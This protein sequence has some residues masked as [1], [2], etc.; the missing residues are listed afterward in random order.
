[1]TR[2]RPKHDRRLPLR[3]SAAL[4]G[5]AGLAAFLVPAVTVAPV[6]AA[7]VLAAAVPAARTA[8]LSGTNCTAQVVGDALARTGWQA[9][10]NTSSSSADAPWHALDGSLSTRFS[11]DHTQAAGMFLQLDLG[12]AQTFDELSLA[13]PGSPTD[14]ARGFEVQVSNNASSWATVASCTGVGVQQVVSFPA[15]TDRYVRVVVTAADAS[16]WW[17]VDE[18]NLYGPV[19]CGASAS[20]SALDRSHWAATANVPYNSSYAPALALDG[21][22]ATRFSTGAVQ[23]AGQYLQVD[24][25]SAHIFDE[26]ALLAPGSPTDYAPGYSVQISNDARSWTTVAS[27]TGTSAVEVT[28]FPP[29][30][31]RY[32]RVMVTQPDAKYWW[33]V[34]ELYLYS[35]VAQPTS[36]TTTSTSTT[37]TTTV[38]SS[39]TQLYSSADPVAA[40]AQVTYTARVTPNPGGGYVNFL[41]GGNSLPGCAQVALNTSNGLATCTTSYDAAGRYSVQAVYSGR[42]SVAGSPAY[43]PSASGVYAEVVNLPPPG[44]LLLSRDGQVFASG[45]AQALGGMT[46]NQSSGPA[47]SIA[48]TPSGRGY[49]LVSANGTVA[50]FGDARFYG[51]LPAL[52]KHVHDIVAIAATSDGKGYYLVGADGGFFTF[53]DATFHGSLPGIHVHVHDVVGMVASPG[54]AGYLLVGADGGVFNFGRARF[55][56]SLPGIHRHV[57]DVRAILPS[58]TGTGYVLVGADGGAFVF[59]TGVRFLGSLPGEGVRVDNVVGIALTPD[60]GGYWMAGADGRVYGFGDAQ[61]GAVPNGVTSNLPVAAIAGT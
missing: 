25:G 48:A 18:L 61:A 9:S 51:D 28:S 39:T 58:S 4:C 41:S 17:S 44:Y 26:V 45:A 37:T 16:Y 31:A 43:R 30:Y 24:T 32:V 54:G 47:V 59:G 3:L 53:G 52:G 23:Q 38:P 49:W 15:Q 10:S 14:Y 34:D 50:A 42:A 6:P 56:G 12:A 13:V 46:V 57:H 60:N 27:C 1:M 40:G 33:S 5:A 7:A 19:N 35:N 20:G 55:Y 29:Q 22:L 21:N 8:G 11:S 2:H 36:T